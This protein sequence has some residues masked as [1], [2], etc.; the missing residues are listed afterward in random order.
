[1][2]KS[3]HFEAVHA[4]KYPLPADLKGQC[5]YLTA[6]E[7]RSSF[8]GN[9]PSNRTLRIYATIVQNRKYPCIPGEI[10]RRNIG[11]PN[12]LRGIVI[13]NDAAQNL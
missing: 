1:M 11:H 7:S 9:L 5:G 8:S 12:Y 10:D 13:N 6:S 3:T 2:A 4:S